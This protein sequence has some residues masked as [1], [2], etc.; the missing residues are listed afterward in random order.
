M[1]GTPPPPPAPP[2]SAP[3][4]AGPPTSLRGIPTTRLRAGRWYREHGHRPSSAD[5]G[6]WYYAPL[7]AD[8]RTG[9]RFDVP[10]PAGTCYFA[11][12]PLT[13]ALERVGRFTA[14]HRPVPADLLADRVVTTVDVADLPATAVHLLAER[15]ATRFGVTGELFTMA[16]CSVPQAWARAIH[17]HG[18]SA[19][20][21]TPRFSPSARAIAV[22][23]AQGPAP[24]ATTSAQ[25]LAAVLHSAGVHVAAIPPA[26]AMR[27]VRAPTS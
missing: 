25:P 19:L 20:V 21:C 11:D 7:P 12:R 17:D 22:F 15:A 24:T 18:H 2:R 3:A 5:G 6:C 8:P 4:Q 13:A 27:F 16:D 1:S 14:Q 10:A 26:S 23:G 9:G